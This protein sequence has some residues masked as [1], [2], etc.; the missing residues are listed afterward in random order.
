MRRSSGA[1]TINK[2]YML[3]RMCRNPPCRNVEV[4][5]RHHSPC[6]IPAGHIPHVLMASSRPD[7]HASPKIATLT[8]I[9]TYVSVGFSLIGA[10]TGVTGCRCTAAPAPTQSGHW[11]PT[12]AD[13]MHIGQIGRMQRVQLTH[14]V[15]AEWR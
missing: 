3:N 8:A 6:A 1:P 9:N 7:I 2:M 14:V 5:R 11:K 12:E 4:N 15:V 10:P 13:V